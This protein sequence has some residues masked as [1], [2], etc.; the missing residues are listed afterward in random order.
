MGFP[1]FY[2][3]LKE[4][5]YLGIYLMRAF[6]F[7]VCLL[8]KANSPRHQSKLYCKRF[9]V[10]K[11]LFQVSP[12]N[13]KVLWRLTLLKYWQEFYLQILNLTFSWVNWYLGRNLGV[14]GIWEYFW[15]SFRLTLTEIKNRLLNFPRSTCLSEVHMFKNGSL[16]LPHLIV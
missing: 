7:L 12:M 14:L 6:N 13:D 3:F 11:Y 15:G 4:D 16:P 1:V 8:L 2:C 10:P 9:Q 5:L